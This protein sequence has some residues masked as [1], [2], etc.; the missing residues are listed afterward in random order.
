MAELAKEPTAAKPIHPNSS[1]TPERADA[2]CRA[3][4]EGA[5]TVGA[6]KL[7]AIH[8]STWFDWLQRIPGVAEKYERAREIRAELFAERVIGCADEATPKTANA[9]RV[10]MDA[11][12]WAASHFAP[13]RYSERQNVELTGRNGGAIEVDLANRLA[14]LREAGDAKNG[15]ASGPNVAQTPVDAA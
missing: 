7:V 11:M 5:G 14:R 12:R 15:S 8:V 13:K 2:I 1:Y 6:C 4:A 3:I 10:R 9:V